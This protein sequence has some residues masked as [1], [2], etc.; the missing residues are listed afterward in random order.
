MSA[1][2]NCKDVKYPITAQ[3]VSI[4]CGGSLDFMG[5]RPL[6][7]FEDRTQ[8]SPHHKE[9]LGLLWTRVSGSQGQWVSLTERIVS[10]AEICL[11]TISS[12][13]LSHFMSFQH[14]YSLKANLHVHFFKMKSLKHFFRSQQRRGNVD[15]WSSLCL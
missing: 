9:P 11:F 2:D 14:S 10:R 3:N 5:L 15:S 4:T 8:G 7:G 6:Q 1:K 13:V 12:C